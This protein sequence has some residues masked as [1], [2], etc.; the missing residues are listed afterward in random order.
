MS[1]MD[2]AVQFV[3]QSHV[4]PIKLTLNS[5]QAT[6]VTDPLDRLGICV[7]QDTLEVAWFDVLDK[8]AVVV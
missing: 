7:L 8:S 3:L 6:D 2:L 5:E 4:V 1:Q